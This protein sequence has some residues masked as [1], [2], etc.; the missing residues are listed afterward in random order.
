MTIVARQN[1]DPEATW[2][3]G[4]GCLK[5]RSNVSE[6]GAKAGIQCVDLGVDDDFL[7]RLGLCYDCAIQVA[8]AIGY[9]S[10]LEGHGLVEQAQAALIEAAEREASAAEAAAQARLD[11][12][13]VE[14]LIGS[15]YQPEDAA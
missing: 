11:R 13:T 5:C 12:D 9:V 3:G 4:A 7:G 14:R 8:L 2:A 6:L 15:V 10:E 1:F